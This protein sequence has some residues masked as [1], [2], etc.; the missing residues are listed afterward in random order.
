MRYQ[1]SSS[2]I[3][4]TKWAFSLPV[5]ARERLMGS[6]A[7]SWNACSE[8]DAFNEN[9]SAGTDTRTA[10]QPTGWVSTDA[11]R[12]RVAPQSASSRSAASDGEPGSAEYVTRARPG[13]AGSGKVS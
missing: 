2:P 13:S 9:G 8:S 3:L 12:V 11:S 4:S 1:V 10:A 6:Q 5:V 7:V